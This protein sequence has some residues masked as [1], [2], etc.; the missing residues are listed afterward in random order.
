MPFVDRESKYPNRYLVTDEFGNQYY[1]TLT[2]ADE[3]VRVGTPLNA[4]TFNK[5]F[6]SVLQGAAVV[7]LLDNAD[8]RHPIN[9]RGVRSFSAGYGID[10]WRA[11]SNMTATIEVDDNG[12]YIALMCSASASARNSITQYI[13]E[14]R[15]PAIGAPVTVAYQDVDGNIYVEAT[16]MPGTGSVRLFSGTG[17]GVTLYSIDEGLRLSIMVP[18]GESV[19]LRWIALY[20]GEYTADTLPWF[21]A[22][23]P[24]ATM[25]EC[26]RYAQ[27]RSVGD[28]D[29]RDLCPP[30]ISTPTVTKISG[31][32]L[33][34]AEP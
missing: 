16:T 1:L 17:V 11:S 30:M 7:N 5:F 15:A 23:K 25:M 6:D 27:I 18:P 14:A 22:E 19:S 26:M 2:R 8:F 32:Y 13:E 33:Y 34:S 12:E 9:Q 31:G 4:A 29:P 24:S 21:R 20:A 3:P 28:I 10:R